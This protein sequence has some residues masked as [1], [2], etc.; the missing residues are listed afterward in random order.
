MPFE[1]RF[2]TLKEL[3]ELFQLTKQRVSFMFRGCALHPGVYP[4]EVVEPELENRNIIARRLPVRTF[5]HP[6]GVTQMELEK[7][8]DSMSEIFSEG[9][10]ELAGPFDTRA[11]ARKYE[12]GIAPDDFFPK[13]PNP[14]LVKGFDGQCYFVD[15]RIADAPI[16]REIDGVVI[17]R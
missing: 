12:D 3:T 5:D 6:G 15:T 7:E 16:I 1:G 2:Y 14:K 10:I 9:V 4:A 13:V 11:E 17:D 8:H